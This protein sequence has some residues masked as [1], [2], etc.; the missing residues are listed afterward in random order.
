ML[1]KEEHY[2]PIKALECG[3]SV[4]FHGSVGLHNVGGTLTV[5][6]EAKMPSVARA[7]N[8]PIHYLQSYPIEVKLGLSNGNGSKGSG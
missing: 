2:T 6:E 7:L 4:V 5:P 3:I 8:R 1:R